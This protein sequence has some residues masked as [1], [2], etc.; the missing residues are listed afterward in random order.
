V[1][2]PVLKPA[3][4]S[5]LTA[6]MLMMIRDV[7]VS[8]NIKPVRCLDCGKGFYIGVYENPPGRTPGILMFKSWDDVPETIHCA[9]HERGTN[10]Q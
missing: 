1:S 10:N 5:G 9:D 8:K 4:K 2:N 3:R 6:R 7:A